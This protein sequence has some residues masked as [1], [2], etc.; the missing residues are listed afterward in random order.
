MLRFME[1]GIWKSAGIELPPEISS[2]ISQRCLRLGHGKRGLKRFV[3]VVAAKL[4]QSMGDD[5]LKRL[6]AELQ[7][8]SI[9]DWKGFVGDVIQG[10]GERDAAQALRKWSGKKKPGSP[11]RKSG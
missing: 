10:G 6:A 4:I 2:V 5:E 3:W 7:S 8:A 9:S 11:G 1:P